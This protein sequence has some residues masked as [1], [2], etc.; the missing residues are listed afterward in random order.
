MTEPLKLQKLSRLTYLFLPISLM[1]L[2]IM[3]PSMV[4]I[5]DML[6]RIKPTSPSLDK[7]LTL[8][9]IFLILLALGLLPL[10]SL[11]LGPIQT[12]MDAF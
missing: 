6:C 5:K 2:V 1:S 8:L 11:K 3:S 9:S 4:K 10:L 12:L 7:W